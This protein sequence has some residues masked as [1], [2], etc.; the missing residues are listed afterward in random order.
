MHFCADN[1]FNQSITQFLIEHSNSTT[2]SVMC[3]ACN[4]KILILICGFSRRHCPEHTAIC[5]RHQYW[6]PHSNNNQSNRRNIQWDQLV[7][8]RRVDASTVALSWSCYYNKPHCDVIVLLGNRLH[9]W[10]SFDSIGQPNDSSNM[11]IE[12]PFLRRGPLPLAM[13]MRSSCTERWAVSKYAERLH[14]AGH[15]VFAPHQNKYFTTY[16][17]Y[18]GAKRHIVNDVE[19]TS[20]G[21]YTHCSLS[22]FPV[23]FVAYVHCLV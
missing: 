11:Q 18:F 19:I 16:C 4:A 8:G 23:F 7:H 17:W 1:K 21:L 9:Y 2:S 22:P 15:D 5:I 10:W 20:V 3:H 6:L 14:I 12:T 13:V